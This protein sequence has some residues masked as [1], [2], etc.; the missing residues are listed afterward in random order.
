MKTTQQIDELRHSIHTW[1][2]QQETIAF[3]PTMGNLHQGHLNLVREAKQHADRVVVSIFVNPMQFGKNE[4]LSNYPRTLVQDREALA[5]LGVDLLFT[6]DESTLYP[7]GMDV[8]TLVQVP[9]LSDILCGASRPG[10]FTGVATVVTKLFHLVQPDVAIFGK[11]DYQQLL[12]IRTLVEHLCF[13]ITIIGVDTMREPSGLAM[14]SRNNYLS[15]SEQDQASILYQTLQEANT[16]L[17]QQRNWVTIKK[18][19]LT[20]WKENGLVPEYL[21]LRQQANLLPPQGQEAQLVLLAAA[22]MGTTRL[23]DNLEIS[24]KT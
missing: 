18:K 12:V 6:P 23:I 9:Y 3:V 4:D 19:I 5:M 7:H 22:F 1:R 8:Q 10:H 20:Q 21:E 17:Q 13:P 16:L 14:S 24:L 15:H 11:K 2:Q